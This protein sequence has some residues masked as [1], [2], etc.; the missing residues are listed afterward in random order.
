[1]FGSHSNSVR[2]SNIYIYSSS[3]SENV[4][5]FD[6]NCVLQP[7][8]PEEKEALEEEVEGPPRPKHWIGLGSERE[9]EEES[10]RETRKK[11][12]RLTKA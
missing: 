7:P 6:S 9:I 8:T 10:V 12:Q 3:F 2:K 5:L 4:F 1:M 11:V